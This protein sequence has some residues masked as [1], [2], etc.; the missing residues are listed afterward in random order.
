MS[1]SVPLPAPPQAAVVPAA[2][3][4]AVGSG[5]RA[6]AVVRAVLLPMVA[7]VEL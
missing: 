5:S 1:R 3:G 6:P 7:A 4:A 2:E